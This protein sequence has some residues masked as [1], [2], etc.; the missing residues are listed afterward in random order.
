MNAAGAPVSLTLDSNTVVIG[1]ATWCPHCAQLEAEL[2]DPAVQS[3]LSGLHIVFAFGNEG[4]AGPGGVVNPEVLNKL[5]GD[6]A[7]LAAG[8]VRPSAYPNAYNPTTGQFDADPYDAISTWYA[9]NQVKQPLDTSET[10]G[11]RASLGS[12]GELLSEATLCTPSPGDYNSDHVVDAADYTIWRNQD[13]S[14]GPDLAAD[15][16]KDQRV[17]SLDYEVW[18]ASF[19]DIVDCDSYEAAIANSPFLTAIS[20]GVD[21]STFIAG[22][23]VESV[24]A[25]SATH[26]IYKIDYF[27]SEPAETGP[28]PSF[29]YSSS[30]P[31]GFSEPLS[32]DTPLTIDTSAH[33][34]SY[35][36]VCLRALFEVAPGHYISGATHIYSWYRDTS[37]ALPGAFAITGPSETQT[38]EN[39][40]VTW[41]AS[42]NAT[43]YEFRL[44]QQPD[45]SSPL[46]DEVVSDTSYVVNIQSGNYWVGVTAI[47]DAGE[48]AANNQVFSIDVQLPRIDLVL[49]VSSSTYSIAS[50]D[51]YPPVAGSF[52]G[53]AAA[54]YQVTSLA[55]EAGLL[56]GPWDGQTIDFRALLTHATTDLVT[57]AGLTNSVYYNTAGQVV[58]NNRAE[59]LSGNFLAPILDEHGNAVTQGLDVWTGALTDGGAAPSK[60]NDWSATTGMVNAGNVNGSGTD[61]ID[62]YQIGCDSQAH[63]F[64]VGNFPKPQTPTLLADIR[65]GTSSSS[66][67]SFTTVGDKTYFTATDGTH[68]REIWVTSGLA[69][70]THRVT[71]IGFQSGGAVSNTLANVNGTLFFVAS[72][73]GNG[74][75]LWKLDAN[76]QQVL[77]KD[78]T[79]GSANEGF[80][81]LTAVGDTLY[82]TA[83]TSNQ[84]GTELWKSD[85]T[86]AG[87]VVVKDIKPGFPQVLIHA[88]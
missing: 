71:G 73:T 23:A 63:L 32:I 12:G 19:G 1:T 15:G 48:T 68:G 85:G 72:D 38:Q 62:A 56:V 11:Q 57:R 77:V 39:V 45:L 83:D 52:G 4:G 27:D 80:A 44:S 5:P 9:S 76:G 78:I 14:V 25:A 26:F 24:G 6:F 84:L 61:W 46:Y 75:A 36:I 86:T 64:A 30:D 81:N 20:D 65:S 67:D 10:P 82:F 41:D 74:P 28:T 43:S 34:D 58:A 7:F 3:A 51:A 22:L 69:P 37:N 87:T 16:N 88:S 47:N 31:T 54:D 42:T 79:P 8:S 60:C 21:E 66:P 2:S 33:A 49:F 13:G 53:V 59:L 18:R 35:V 50:D 70:S 40:V 17:D 29:E 55:N